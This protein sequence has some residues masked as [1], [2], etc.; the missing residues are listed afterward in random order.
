MQIF[1]VLIIV[2]CLLT[3]A[4]SV[5]SFA[6]WVPCRSKD[7]KRIFNLADLKPKEVFYDLGCGNGKTVIYANK[8]F[9]AKS[10]G[11]ELAL[12]LFLICKIR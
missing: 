1:I 10:I 11:I 3:I 12:P 5:K 9:Q 7:L 4:I 6:P 8:N 2:I